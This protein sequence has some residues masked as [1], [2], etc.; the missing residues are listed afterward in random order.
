MSLAWRRSLQ[1]LLYMALWGM[2]SVPARAYD[3]LE[4]YSLARA[5][6]PVLEAARQ[7][8]LAAGY[9]VDQAVGGWQPLIGVNG[10]N[11]KSHGDYQFGSTPPNPATFNQRQS[12]NWNWTLQLTQ[13]IWKPVQT[14]LV[15]QAQK[16]KIQYEAQYEQAKQELFSRVATSYFAVETAQQAVMAAKS[17]VDA[18]AVQYA[19]NAKGY[20][21][22]THSLSDRE[23]AKAKWELAKS[24][25]LGAQ[26]EL[27][28]QFAEL[29]KL[30]GS[31][32][33]EQ[34]PMPRLSPMRPKAY[35]TAIEPSDIR[36]WIQ[37]A[38]GESPLVLAKLAAVKAAA[39][40]V[41]KNQAGH[42]PT[43]DLVASR[44]RS[45]ASG[46]NTPS[47]YESRTWVGNVGVQLN[48][49]LFA[50]NTNV[51]KTREAIAQMNAAQA[52]LESA[53][54]SVESGVVAAFKA[55]GNHRGQIE[56]LN[57]AIASAQ[58]ALAGNQAGLRFGLKIRLDVLQAEAQLATAKRDWVKAR[59]DA[60]LQSIKLKVAAGQMSED[61]VVDM[62]HL[63]IPEEK[64]NAPLTLKIT[65][66]LKL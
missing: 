36:A 29:E 2:V 65:Q 9:R 61:D 24:Q 25:R 54:R 15:T 37:Q 44:S 58:V 34:N 23:E 22:G 66:E 55:V 51:A 14:Q 30:T 3:F 43:L 64:K 33:N 56:A 41:A 35:L 45:Y 39:A 50:G 8:M 47:D 32:T 52:D 63:F 49:P 21:A 38:R 19:I 7:S 62:N 26:T 18:G 20:E 31:L 27:D 59:Y 12:N 11:Q 17:A 53:E 13:P 6:D 5:N 48:I 57:A 10:L 46:S 1:V 16:I 28:T 60:L 40:E 4:I 42:Q